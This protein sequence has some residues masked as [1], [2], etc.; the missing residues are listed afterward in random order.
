MTSV[1]LLRALYFTLFLSFKLRICSNGIGGDVYVFFKRWG[2]PILE[3]EGS[4][5]K[6]EDISLSSEGIRVYVRGVKVKGP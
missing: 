1:L 3:I 2:S 5:D 6:L 4:E